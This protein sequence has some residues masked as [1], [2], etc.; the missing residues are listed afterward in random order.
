MLDEELRNRRNIRRYF[1][2]GELWYLLYSLVHAAHDF[3]KI[4]T[5]IGD[6]RPSNIF[7]NE[8]GQVKIANM[9]SWP[10]EPTNYIK[11]LDDSQKTYLAPE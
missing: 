3:K 7:I 6:V 2:E 8:E 9:F 1:D 10:N 11:T 4:G 5:K